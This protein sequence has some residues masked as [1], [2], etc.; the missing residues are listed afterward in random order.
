MKKLIIAILAVT[1]TAA[2]TILVLGQ[3]EDTERP[4][5]R[6]HARHGKFGK[7][8][9][10][11]G[12]LFRHLD[13]TEAQKD[14]IKAIRQTSRDNTQAIREGM[15]ETR[16]QIAELGT[17]GDLDLALLDQL[18]TQQAEYHKQ[19]IIERQKTKVQMLSVLTPEQ[20]AKLEDLKAGARERMRER[21]ERRQERFGKS[22][23]GQ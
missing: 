23:G 19:M 6:A 12:R 1:V 4:E 17:K 10:M 11:A 21:F 7:R 14:Q 8:G 20:K 15:R 3:T 5:K 16:K 9:M 13:L 22:Q 18:A 2:G